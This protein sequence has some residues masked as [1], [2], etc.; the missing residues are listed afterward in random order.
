[1]TPYWQFARRMLRYRLLFAASVAMVVM[2]AFSLGV[3]LL[4]AKPVMDA[5]LDKGQDLPELAAGLNAKFEQ[6]GV[7]AAFRVPQHVIDSLPPGEFTALVWIMPGLALLAVI[8][9]TTTFLHAFLAHTIVNRT[10]TAVRREAFH[11]T[12]RSPLRAVVATGSADAVSRIVNDSTQLSMGLTVL[13]SKAVLQ[14]FKGIAGLTAAIIFD[15]RVTFFYVLVSTEIYT[16]I[17]KL[18]KKIKRASGRALK[19]QA[20]LYETASQAMHALKVVKVHTAE[21]LEGGRFHRINKEVLRELNRVRTARALASPLTEMLTIFLL[22]GLVLVAGRAIISGQIDPGNFILAIAA[23][24]VAGASLKPL[25]GIVND[26]QTASPAADRLQQLLN[27]PQEPGHGFRLP[28]LPRHEKSLRFE[29][30]TFRYPGAATPAL[31][32]VDIT[33][34][35]GKLYAIVGPTGSGKTTLLGLVPRLFDP[36][37]GRVLVDGHDIREYSVRSLRAQ[38]GMVTQEVVLFKGTVRSNIAY[39][40]DSVTDDAIIAAA[41]KARAH[42]FISAMGDGYDTVVAEQGMSLSGGQRQRIAIARAILRD[43]RILIL[44]EATSMVDAES[45]GHIAAALAEF[46][47]GRTSLI[48]AHRMATVQ[49]ADAIIVMSEGRIIDS[50]P[51]ATL[52]ERCDLYRQI[53]ASQFGGGSGGGGG[54]DAA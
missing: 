43:P 24:A 16:V 31:R 22:C 37:E 6:E 2:S 7:S 38:I 3:G 34:E 14:I 21:R 32:G 23:L 50:A 5:I 26:I 27:A 51:H 12:I 44:D 49:G 33:L 13:L 42:E 47:K 40:A 19:G 4:G 36:D 53:I 52:M 1:M 8:G 25:T 18:G 20:E 54:L 45:E 11:A 10:I 48:V 41:R 39:G 9:S 17:R 30:V 15:W 29:S 46:A 35:H 28:R